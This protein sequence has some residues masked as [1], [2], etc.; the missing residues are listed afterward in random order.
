MEWRQYIHELIAE[1]KRQPSTAIVGVSGCHYKADY[2]KCKESNLL[3][4]YV[5]GGD[6]FQIPLKSKTF[7]FADNYLKEPYLDKDTIK[8]IEEIKK[9][10]KVDPFKFKA[11]DFALLKEYLDYIQKA[12]NV[13]YDKSQMGKHGSKERKY[14]VILYKLLSDK[15]RSDMEFFD[16]EFQTIAEMNHGIEYV[17]D[18]M[19][20]GGDVGKLHAGKPDYIAFN[21]EG[22]II[23]ELKT[24]ETACDGSVGLGEHNSDFDNIILRNKENQIFVTELLRRIQIM[25]EFDL[26]SEKWK[27]TAR[28][29]L[30]MKKDDIKLCAKYLFITNPDFTKEM[31]KKKIK[32]Y[33]FSDDECIIVES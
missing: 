20:K 5:N 10:I 27:S 15:P 3:R 23:V 31:C 22:F 6:A 33:G 25:Y 9:A 1:I 24:N 30:D 32:D 11:N 29:I 18:W 13:K 28:C 19:E 14:Q 17:K 16:M 4:V 2:R 12:T 21:K 8:R 7:K 26:V